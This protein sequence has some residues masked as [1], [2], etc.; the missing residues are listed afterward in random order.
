MHT[1]DLRRLLIRLQGNHGILEVPTGAW[2]TR[3]HLCDLVIQVAVEMVLE[4]EAMTER[5][6]REPGFRRLAHDALYY[7]SR[8]WEDKQYDLDL[9]DEQEAAFGRWLVGRMG[10]EPED[11]RKGREVSGAGKSAES[12]LELAEQ[13]RRFLFERVRELA[14]LLSDEDAFE[15]AFRVWEDGPGTSSISEELRLTWASMESHAAPVLP[16][17]EPLEEGEHRHRWRLDYSGLDLHGPEVPVA[18]GEGEEDAALGVEADGG[19]FAKV[20]R[21]RAFAG[22]FDKLRPVTLTTLASELRILGISPAWSEVERA[23]L[24]LDLARAGDG[25]P[26]GRSDFYEPVQKDLQ[27]VEDFHKLLEKEHE[28]LALALL[29]GAVLGRAARQAERFGDR[30]LAGLRAISRMYR[31]DAQTA[32]ARLLALAGLREELSEQGALSGNRRPSPEL[33]SLS[34]PEWE[35]WIRQVRQEGD[36][37]TV[38]LPVR[39]S[40]R[41]AWRAWEERLTD[42]TSNG[43]TRFEPVVSDLWCAA[44]DVPPSDLLLPDLKAMRLGDWSQVV[45]AA[46]MGSSKTPGDFPLYLAVPALYALGFRVSE[47]RRLVE[48]L[49]RA[50]GSRQEPTSPGGPGPLFAP[51]RAER[52]RHPAPRGSRNRQALLVRRSKS[53]LTEGWMPAR[54]G[55]V[56]SLTPEQLWESA[57]VDA[58]GRQPPLI[59]T[60]DLDLIVVELAPS[61]VPESE[62][63]RTKR[64]ERGS[65]KSGELKASLGSMLTF[66]QPE[67]L[68]EPARERGADSLPSSTSPPTLR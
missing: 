7:P 2:R 4:G 3:A 64:S 31:F 32:G 50:G 52:S 11:H 9:S 10:R 45:F 25:T 40:Q 26:D 36:E 1:I 49:D 37:G 22:L 46:V 53:S 28:T 59:A 60:L 38:T 58:H 5:L 65:P 35:S 34:L 39:D 57:L 42:Y 43:R 41:A 67:R 66:S 30:L 16:L 61:G 44:A 68:S 15:L 19:P 55:A 13:D 27:T 23:L 17:L 62:A 8:H 24:R 29:C 18:E 33:Q 14:H 20:D 54:Q 12:E 6:R 51:M 48:A 21:V 56:L 63:P 47:P